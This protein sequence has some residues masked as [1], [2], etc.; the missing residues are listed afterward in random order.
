MKKDLSLSALVSDAAMVNDYDPNAMS[1]E[2]EKT[3]I[4]HFLHNIDWK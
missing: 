3:W 4:N 1:V 2:K